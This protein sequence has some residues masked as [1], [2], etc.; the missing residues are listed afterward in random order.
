MTILQTIEEEKCGD[1]KECSY[2]DLWFK[3]ERLHIRSVKNTIKVTE[4]ENAMKPGKSCKTYTLFWKTY[5]YNRYG[6]LLL[7]QSFGEMPLRRFVG[8]L[9]G[10][11]YARNEAALAKMGISYSERESKGTQTYSPF[12]KV[13][14]QDLERKLTGLKV[15]KA[16]MA[17]QI[18]KAICTGHYT[19]DYKYDAAVNFGIGQEKDINELAKELIES[20]GGRWWARLSD[21]KKS[22]SLSPYPNLSYD[23]TI[24]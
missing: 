13:K 19:D 10:G 23:L 4:L 16:I 3:E 6:L 1:G 8:R 17:G 2:F 24:A 5:Q 22:V 7:Y 14:K 15:G 20:S 21:N 12:V 9:Q 11:I 18:A